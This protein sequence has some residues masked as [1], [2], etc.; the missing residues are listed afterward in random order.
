MDS[1]APHTGVFA[2]ARR[3]ILGWRHPAAGRQPLPTETTLIQGLA[4]ARWCAWGWVVVT[5]VLQ[6]DTLSRPAIATVLIIC[7]LLFCALC[8]VLVLTAKHWLLSKRLATAELVLANIMLLADGWVFDEGHS[9]GRTQSL[10]SSGPLVAVMAAAIVLGPR[11]GAL[12][13]AGTGISRIGGGFVNGVREW[14][15]DRLLS[16]SSTVIQYAIAALMFGLVANRMRIVEREVL[17]RRAKDEIASALHDGVLQTLALVER[18]TRTT[19]PSLAAEAR[20]SDRELRSWLF[21]SPHDRTAAPTFADA[22]RAT[23]DRV[24]LTHDLSV[25]VNC[26]VVEDETADAQAN[27]AIIAAVGEA[28]VNVAKH[29][30]TNEAVVFADTEPNGTVFVS[31][32]DRGSG[33]ATDA[34]GDDRHGLAGSITRRVQNAGGKVDIVSTVGSGTE[35]RM[36]NNA[37][38]AST[39]S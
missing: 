34:V 26:L 5:T 10:A 31:V 30:G 11:L 1:A 37:L 35:I 2:R 13:A 32:R 12:L 36:W 4:V 19:D 24:S 15:A 20:R 29:A 7:A 23:V 39:T 16:V 27:E 6:R 14:P 25:V 3:H 22:L 28:L 17:T 9:F 18:R 8:T 21:H 38:G 33:F